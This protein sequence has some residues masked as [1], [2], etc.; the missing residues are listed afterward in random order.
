MFKKIFLLL[1]MVLVLAIPTEA[2]ASFVRQN[3]FL[4]EKNSAEKTA[5]IKKFQALNNLVA[6][7]SF[8]TLTKSVLYDEAYKVA[9][10]VVSPPTKDYWIVVNTTTRVLTLYKGNN[11]VHKYAVAVGTSSTPTPNAKGTISNKAVNPAWGGMFGKYEPKAANDPKNPLGERWL[12][13][14]LGSKHRGYGI[15]GTILPAQIGRTVSNGCIR[16]FNYDIEEELFPI[17]KVGTPVWLGDAK[18]L[19]SWGVTQVVSKEIV[20]ATENTTTAPTTPIA[21]V[22]VPVL[23]GSSTDAVVEE[24]TNTTETIREEQIE[25]DVE[26]GIQTIKFGD[27]AY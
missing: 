17:V 21:D 19:E 20:V 22:T 7:G 1:A 18:T 9:D 6:D 15:H 24:T 23:D 8:G 25:Q 10:T 27:I 14:N 26:A 2:H 3:N 4:N 16:M 5:Q 12:G 13:L 11:V